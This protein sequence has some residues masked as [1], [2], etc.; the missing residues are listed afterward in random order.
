[1]KSGFLLGEFE[2]IWL[3]GG[4]FELDGGAMF[5]VVP[6]TLWRK[7]YPATQDNYISMN[8][9]P[10][11]VRTPKALVMIES[12]FGN[13]LTEKQNRI[14]RVQQPWSIPDELQSLGIDRRDIDYVILTHFDFDHAGGVVM[15]NA[16]GSQEITFPNARHILQKREWEDVMKPNA[17]SINTYWP[18]NNE[19]MRGRA[20][21]EFVDGDA[22]I[23]A[24]VSVALTGGHTRGHQVVRLESNASRAVHL[25]DLCPTHAHINPLW[26]MA[27]DNFPLDTITMKQKLLAQGADAR[28][29][30]TFYHD[31]YVLAC[32]LDNEG[33]IL[34]RFTE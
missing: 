32:R 26:V 3:N 33:N 18:V 24:G 31:P 13:K 1:M 7:K 12:G 25:G 15:L 16:S 9:W 4:R 6:K 8:A 20:N 29:W 5:G 27:Y 21:I 22:E 30:F 14:F 17:R 23:I 10:I 11:L 19:L 2:L 28:T 34:E